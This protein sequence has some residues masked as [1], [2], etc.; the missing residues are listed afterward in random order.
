MPTTTEP[1]GPLHGFLVVD[2]THAVAGPLASM[3]LA[4]L[5]ARVVKVEPPAGDG[6]R[7]LGRPEADRYLGLFETYNRGKE[8]VVLDLREDADR[9]AARRLV[10]R[11]D[12]LVQAFRPGVMDRLGLGPDETRARNPRLVYT[13]VSGYGPGEDRRG[14]DTALQGE[15][16]WMSITGEPD[17]PPTKIGALPI[18]V[19]T[20]HVAAQAVLAALLN[21]ERRGHGDLVEVSLY[22]VGCH[23]H[24]HDFTDY[25][26]TGQVAARTGNHMGLSAP[27]GVFAT[28]DGAL[29]L[30]TYLPEH[31]QVIVDALGEE[32]LR[33]DP[34]F[35]T[36]R[37]RQAHGRELVAAVER[38]TRTR[39]TRHWTAVFDRARLT[40]GEVL[41]T[42]QVADSG[43]FARNRLE[44]HITAGN[45]REVRTVRTPARFGSFSP[46]SPL[47]APL[48]GEHQDH[49]LELERL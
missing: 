3:L 16:G 1:T 37:D 6:A 47:P 42:G 30:A 23:L 13:S 24:A 15:T 12:V 48:L 4:D 36:P 17:G 32:S 46:T 26:M 39:T 43:R 8:S 5:G 44:L 22:D 9:A 45:G 19:A 49:A 28:A 41:D 21:R 29:V 20:G 7:R 18:D 35:G 14:V 34:R 27:S 33:T 38:V 10:D 40:S 2:F 31:W 25:L 11:A